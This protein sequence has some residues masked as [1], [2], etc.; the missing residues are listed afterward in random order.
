M[1]IGTIYDKSKKTFY[2]KSYCYV[3]PYEMIPPIIGKYNKHLKPI[4]S[5][6]MKWSR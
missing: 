6:I 1:L 3:L 5:N 4:G 2:E